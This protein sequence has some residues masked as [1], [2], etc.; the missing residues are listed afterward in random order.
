MSPAYQPPT[1]FVA[2]VDRL[3]ALALVTCT[4]TWEQG[5]QVGPDACRSIG[6]DPDCPVCGEVVDITEVIEHPDHLHLV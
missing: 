3:V 1:A 2:E 5:G 6:C 4:C